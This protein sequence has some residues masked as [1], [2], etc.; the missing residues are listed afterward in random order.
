[1][2]LLQPNKT[3]IH[4]EIPGLKIIVPSGAIASGVAVGLALI[5]VGS[6]KIRGPSIC[7]FMN[8]KIQT[9][10]TIGHF[11]VNALLIRRGVISL[12]PA[13]H[14]SG[15]IT[16]DAFGLGFECVDSGGSGA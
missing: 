8:L 9:T 11:S 16:Q 1:M 6:D 5:N 2:L 13:K 3:L 14:S 4:R 15:Q 12:A 10:F 7:R